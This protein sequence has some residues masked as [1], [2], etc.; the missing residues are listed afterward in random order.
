MY[1]LMRTQVFFFFYF[2]NEY[3]LIQPCYVTSLSEIY[4]HKRNHSKGS[5]K[6]LDYSALQMKAESMNTEKSIGKKKKKEK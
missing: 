5:T 6:S 4:G 1:I 3:T 2:W